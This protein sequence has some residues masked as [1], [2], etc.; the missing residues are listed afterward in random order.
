MKSIMGLLVLVLSV[1]AH[2]ITP[3]E[4]LNG[5]KFFDT[6]GL[7]QKVF[8]DTY[9]IGD[10]W[11]KNEVT[12]KD[13]N[14]DVHYRR[15]ALSTAKVRGGGTG[16][17]MGVH[18]GRHLLATNNHVCPSQFK[19]SRK[20]A[21]NFTMLGVKATMSEWM[22]SWTDIDLAIFAIEFQSEEDAAKLAG[23]ASPFAFNDDLYR[24]QPLV[25]IGYGMADNP[26]RVLVG[27]RD[28]D[29]RVYSGTAEY[30]HMKDPD[31]LNPGK[32]LVWSFANGCDVSHGDSGSAMMDRNTG[33]V[34]G[35]IWTGRI[36]KAEKVQSS[37]FMRGL[38][39]NPTEE[40]WQELSYGVPAP[41]IATH[42]LDLIERGQIEPDK[43]ATLIALMS[44][45]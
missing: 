37:A 20:G 39:E 9:R 8:N 24:G 36:P 23:L 1:Q 32:N 15:M 4:I 25:T 12:E 29:C 45:E 16:F 44:A 3:E 31:D 2:A 11:G 21:V 33:K 19:C 40:I 34:I 38:L 6:N 26:G 27:N 41:M 28:D 35:I 13:L 30:R 7:E 22:G 18:N 42:L 5:I 17:Y 43:A 14:S 10:E